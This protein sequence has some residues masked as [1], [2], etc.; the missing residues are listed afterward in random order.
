MTPQ[1]KP[2]LSISVE[3]HL[4]AI[5]NQCNVSL[6]DTTVINPEILLFHTGEIRKSFGE[7]VEHSEVEVHPCAYSYDRLSAYAKTEIE[8][9]RDTPW[10]YV[11][12]NTADKKV[13]FV[14]R[15]L[16]DYQDS[17]PDGRI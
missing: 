1:A 2:T 13:A 8:A 14:L 4:Q 11:P 15:L 5:E 16:R 12:G 3:A 17:N 10:N 9:Q 6:S 7:M